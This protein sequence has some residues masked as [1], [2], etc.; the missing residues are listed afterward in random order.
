MKFHNL[1]ERN[2]EKERLEP[3]NLLEHGEYLTR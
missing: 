3:S 2:F 1:A